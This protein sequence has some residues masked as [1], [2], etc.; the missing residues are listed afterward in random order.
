MKQIPSFFGGTRQGMAISWSARIKDKAGIR[1]HF[2]HLIDIVPTVLEV[3]GIRAPDFV[4]GV[5]QKPIEGVSLAYTFEKENANAPSP[6][7]MKLLRMTASEEGIGT[8]LKSDPFGTHAL[9]RK[10]D[11]GRCAR[12]SDPSVGR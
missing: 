3:T 11:R 1:W 8:L 4:D 2:H 6:H 10:A 7:H 12:T 9:S 5:A